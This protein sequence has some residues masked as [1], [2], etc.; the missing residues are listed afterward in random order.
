MYFAQIDGNNLVLNVIVADEDFVKLL[1]GTWVRTDINGMSPKNYAGIGFMWRPDLDGFLP[2]KPYLSWILNEDRCD[3]EPPVP[4][5]KD[6]N[7][8][9]WDEQ[10]LSWKKIE[11]P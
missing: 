11:Q 8:Y 5:P 2:P 4:M 1:P 9:F 3:W 6:E 7:S 10:D